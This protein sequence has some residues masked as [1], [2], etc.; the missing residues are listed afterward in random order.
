M[1]I[2]GRWCFYKNVSPDL[3]IAQFTFIDT[4]YSLLDTHTFYVSIKNKVKEE[5]EKGEIL[6]TLTSSLKV[7]DSSF[8]E[9]TPLSLA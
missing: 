3:S 7:G 4:S 5:T 9:V 8:S 2:D 6:L 1:A